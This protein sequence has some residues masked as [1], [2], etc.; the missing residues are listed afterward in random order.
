MHPLHFKL[1]VSGPNLNSNNYYGK[2]LMFR[3][4]QIRFFDTVHANCKGLIYMANTA[5]KVTL[6]RK[7]YR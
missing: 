2:K 3:F 4:M 7:S 5:D 6:P 1:Q